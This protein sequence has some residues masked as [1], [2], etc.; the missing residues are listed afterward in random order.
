M[1][2]GALLISTTLSIVICVGHVWHLNLPSLP[3]GL[4]I[5][6][7]EFLLIT[8]P[9]VRSI[10]GFEPLTP[11]GSF[12]TGHMKTSWNLNSY[13]RSIST[14]S[15]TWADFI[16][17]PVLSSCI[18]FASFGSA[19]VLACVVNSNPL[20]WLNPTCLVYSLTNL[21]STWDHCSSSSCNGLR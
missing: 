14:G 13:P 18:V 6:L 12:E 2:T 7:R 3:A 10:G 1:E 4:A 11:L 9:H 16:Q 17:S 5:R 8:W 20:S 21:A 19:R 15:S